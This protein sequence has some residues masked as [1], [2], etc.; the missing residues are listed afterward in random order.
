MTW[1]AMI[2]L[3]YRGHQNHT[4]STLKS[5]SCLY[6]APIFRERSA[7]IIDRDINIFLQQ[8][9]YGCQVAKNGQ[10]VANLVDKNDVNLG[11]LPRFRQVSIE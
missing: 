7:Y 11:L 3:G 6:S 9:P 2:P 5:G 1:Q 10:Q 4:D 8:R